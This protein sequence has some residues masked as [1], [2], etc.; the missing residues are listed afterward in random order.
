[1]E[2]KEYIETIKA[3]KEEIISKLLKTNL[4]NNRK[5]KKIKSNYND[6]EK[7]TKELSNEGMESLVDGKKKAIEK[8]VVSDVFKTQVHIEAI[9]AI[10]DDTMLDF[11]AAIRTAKNNA[12]KTIKDTLN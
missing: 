3:M 12:D 8:G 5:A 9:E 4:S 1:M 11:K 2:Y 7:E 10:T 6:V